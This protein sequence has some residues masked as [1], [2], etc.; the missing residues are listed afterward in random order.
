MISINFKKRAFTSL[1]LFF[2]IIL[3]FNSYYIFVLSLLIAGVL[4][5]LEFLNISRKI[6]KSKLINFFSN[7][8]FI[9][10][11]FLFCYLF[12][13]FYN[14]YQL[15]VITFSL[16]I[17]CI[18]SDIGGYIFGN[19]F[20]GPRLTTISPNKT[21]SGAFGSMLFT[22]IVLSFLLFN[23]TG[24][25]NLNTFIISVFT[26]IGCQ[27]G[28]LFFSL[29]KRKAKLKDTGNILPGH[30]GVLDR[31]DGILFGIPVG[32]ITLILTY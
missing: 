1:L 8:F 14:F 7:I 5:I 20:K 24:N 15:K 2:L 16:L 18:A 31:I 29:L 23:F 10:Y 6:S 11:I 19:I 26:S 4:S 27:S 22:F 28:D 12:L 17:G 3:I 9:F 21:I 25:F 30:G 13:F 32:Y